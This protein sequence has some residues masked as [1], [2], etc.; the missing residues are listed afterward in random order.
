MIDSKRTREI[1]DWET[2]IKNV[3]WVADECIA[4]Q[5][6][7]ENNDGRLRHALKTESMFRLRVMV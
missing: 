5:Q 7:L 2:H 4:S 3:G 1:W 6:A